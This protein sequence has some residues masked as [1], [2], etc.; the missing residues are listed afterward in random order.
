MV[1]ASAL[2]KSGLKCPVELDK[3]IQKAITD[4][5]PISVSKEKEKE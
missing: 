4:N 2:D 3:D 5:V 1:I